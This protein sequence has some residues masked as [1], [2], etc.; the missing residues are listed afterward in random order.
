[1]LLYLVK[2]KRSDI[3]NAGLDDDNGELVQEKN[4]INDRYNVVSD[5]IW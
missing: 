5:E 4:R 1:M 3:S 2:H